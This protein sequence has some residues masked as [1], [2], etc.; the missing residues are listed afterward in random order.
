MAKKVA[1][2]KIK[3]ERKITKKPLIKKVKEKPE[4]PKV[5]VKEKL[6]FIEC[7]FCLT[8]A[9]TRTGRD[10]TS[11]WCQNCGKCIPAIWKEE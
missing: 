3:K 2:S 6:K 10:E 4:E 8:R 5:V 1:E 11:S 7:P 9:Y